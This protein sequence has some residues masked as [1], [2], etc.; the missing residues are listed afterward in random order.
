MM[1]LRQPTAWARPPGPVAPGLRIGLLG[2]SFNPAHDGHI[3]ASELALKQLQL[4]YVW[5]LVSPQ[6]PLKPAEG[7]AGFENRLK[8]ARSLARQ[9]RI[10]VTGIEAQLG[11]SYTAD[12]L[13]ALHKRFPQLRFVWLMG[14]DNLVQLPRWRS[15]QNIFESVPVAVVAR[16]G[17]ALAARRS[18]AA[19]RFRT[20]YRPPGRHFSVTTLPVW[21]MLE[22]KRNFTSATRL[23]DSGLAIPE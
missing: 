2:G 8:R 12:T 18:K 15:W 4:D 10:V 19:D 22:G 13:R 1:T 17:T 16:P 5:W 21:T 11:T 14:S 7:M 6:N 23:R 20:A 9:R 3:H